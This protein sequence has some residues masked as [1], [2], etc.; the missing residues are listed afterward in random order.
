MSS[1]NTFNFMMSKILLFGNSLSNDKILD[2]TNLNAFEDNKLKKKKKNQMMISFFRWLEKLL[3]RGENAGYQ[4]F[5]LFP[6]C[7]QR[8]SF[9]WSSKH[10]IACQTKLSII[11]VRFCIKR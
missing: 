5:L 3:G 7:F 10:G 4:H 6:R 8:V 2:S 9:P 11:Y 1:A